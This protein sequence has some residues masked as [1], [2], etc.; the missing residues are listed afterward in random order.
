MKNSICQKSSFL[1]K[2]SLELEFHAFYFL[3][4]SLIAYNSIFTKLSFSLKI[5]F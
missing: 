3:F 5:N 2:T 1:K 4:L